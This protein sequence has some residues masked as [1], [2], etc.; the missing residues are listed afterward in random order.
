[1]I[2]TLPDCTRQFIEQGAPEGQRQNAAFNAACQCR[3]AGGTEAEALALIERGAATC[4]LPASDARA[5]VRSA[6]KHPAREPI[7]TKR[8]NGTDYKNAVQSRPVRPPVN[9]AAAVATT[10][11]TAKTHG[12]RHVVARYD[13]TDAAGVAVAA[14]ETAEA[15]EN[16]RGKV[17]AAHSAHNTLMQKNLS[18]VEEEKKAKL[19]EVNNG[20]LPWGYP[21]IIDQATMAEREAAAW[22]PTL[23]MQIPPAPHDSP[24]AKARRTLQSLAVHWLGFDPNS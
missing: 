9:T 24:E 12:K 19:R 10:R 11:A 17:R 18:K 14:V 3:D 8:N 16:L 13:Y 15:R 20:E 5:A 6:Y 2:A 21:N 7:T 22:T 1:M 23:A 4:G